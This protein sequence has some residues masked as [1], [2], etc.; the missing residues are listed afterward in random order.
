MSEKSKWACI[1]MALTLSITEITSQ[2][3]ES[4]NTPAAAHARIK[5][6]IRPTDT[7]HPPNKTQI[8]QDSERNISFNRFHKVFSA[9]LAVTVGS[10]LSALTTSLA[11]NSNSEPEPETVSQPEPEPDWSKAFNEWGVAWDIHVYLFAVTF[12]GF[13]IYSTFF[14]GMNLYVG[15]HQRYLG[16]CLNIVMFILGFT[17][18]FVLFTDPYMQGTTINNPRALRFMWA[19]GSP[20]LTSS[21]CLVILALVETAKIS[22]A[23]QSMQKFSVILKVILCHFAYVIT[24]EFVVSKF[25][26]AKVLLVVCQGFFIVWGTILGVGYFILAYKLDRKLFGQRELKSKRDVLYIRLIYASGV[27]NF[28]LSAL[29][30][31]ASVSDFGVY[32][33]SKFVDAW[34]W[35]TLESCLRVIEVVASLL[36]FTVSAKRKSLKK[37]HTE[38]CEESKS[39]R[40]SML[41]YFRSRKLQTVE[42]KDATEPDSKG[43]NA[44][45]TVILETEIDDNVTE[46]SHNQ[47][48]AGKESLSSMFSDLHLCKVQQAHATED[49]KGNE[50]VVIDINLKDTETE[51]NIAGPSHE[52]LL[53]A[54]ESLMSMFSHLQLNK[55]HSTL[56]PSN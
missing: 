26:G 42:T 2:R 39:R 4:S 25:I 12:L 34:S 54:K 44:V 20:C 46:P 51:D 1:M 10:G 11:A 50:E 8:F 37:T 16:F 56:E 6:G 35:W 31:Y 22:V 3:R 9:P 36:I 30:L 45:L 28:I 19:L 13:A 23:P 29:F 15:L 41:N 40:I 49:L 21:D 27:N 43:E 47:L 55:E 52:Q 38:K 5:H 48:V 18:A 53:G 32:S 24:T 14:I 33:D 7:S 17:R